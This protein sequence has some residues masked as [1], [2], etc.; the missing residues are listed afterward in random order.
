[1]RDKSYFRDV[2]NRK[3]QRKNV[4]VKR[5]MDLIGIIMM[6]SIQKVK[7]IVAVD[8]VSLA[9]DMDCRQSKICE[10]SPERKYC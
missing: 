2:R 4:L 8:C 6:V 10:S 7:Y 3:I 1:M 9:K 5:C